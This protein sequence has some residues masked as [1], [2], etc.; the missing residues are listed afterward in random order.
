M[1]L[2]ATFLILAVMVASPHAAVGDEIAKVSRYLSGTA[3]GLSFSGTKF[4]LSWQFAPYDGRKV[5]KW[6]GGDSVDPPTYVVKELQ[7]SLSGHKVSIPESAYFDIFDPP[8]QAAGP[9]ILEDSQFLY[10][11]LHASDGAG[12]A[13]VSLR[14]KNGTYIDREVEKH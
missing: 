12:S 6:V 4:S 9:Y 13:K 1:I 11:V 7:L 5:K 3:S 14:F 2:R 8:V 10:L